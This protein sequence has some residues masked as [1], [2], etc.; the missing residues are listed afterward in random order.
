VLTLL[1]ISLVLF[2]GGVLFAY[3]TVFRFAAGFLL[4]VA[5]EGL[6]AMISVSR[7]VSF[8]LAFLLP[9]GFIFQLPLVI[10][11]LTRAGIISAQLLVKNRKYVILATF[12]IGAILTPPDVVSQVFM[13][14]T[15]IILYEV[16]ILTAR[17]VKRKPVDYDDDLVQADRTTE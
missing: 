3:Y 10:L 12:I 2:A 15:M 6:S 13:A 11:F 7:Y 5:G 14:G 4:M 9:F 17:L 16:S 8:L 1:P